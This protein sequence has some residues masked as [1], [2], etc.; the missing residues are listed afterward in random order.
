ME[1]IVETKNLVK[2]YGQNKVINDVTIH[3]KPGEIYGLIGKNGAGKTTLMRL[4]LGLANKTSG[5][6]FLYGKEDV[7]A[8]RK[9]IGSLIE[10]PALY[11]NETAFENLKRMSI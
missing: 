9:K 10:E 7:K 6:I 8:S 5:S 2:Q 3:V 11:K 1:Y 4:I